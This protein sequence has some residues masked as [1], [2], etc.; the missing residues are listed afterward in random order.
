MSLKHYLHFLLHVWKLPHVCHIFPATTAD[1]LQVAMSTFCN[2]CI[3]PPHPLP[4]K[5][6]VPRGYPWEFYGICRYSTV[7]TDQTA[8]KGAAPVIDRYFSILSL[9]DPSILSS[10]KVSLLQLAPK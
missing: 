9:C 10:Y 6:M 1:I 7:Q 2:Q 4:N 5:Y 3:T 8:I